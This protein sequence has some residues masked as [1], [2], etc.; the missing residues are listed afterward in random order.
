MELSLKARRIAFVVL[1]VVALAA[2]AVALWATL[3]ARADAG[4]WLI[5]A[6][7]VLVLAL[8]GELVLLVFREKSS[9][10][11]GG[12]WY[13]WESQTKGEEILLRCP[14]CKETFTL[15]DT[16]QRPLK[17]AC[18]HCG[19]QGVLNEK[20]APSKGAARNA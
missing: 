18:P 9:V 11:E 14:N 12:D 17:H 4:T 15:L 2:L 20:P 13:N 5:A 16:G 3:S 1:L 7:V 10:D 19:R 8:A 6:V